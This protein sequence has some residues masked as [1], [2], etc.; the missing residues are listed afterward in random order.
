[1]PATLWRLIDSPTGAMQHL[2][3]LDAIMNTVR[4]ALEHLNEDS[5][6]PDICHLVHLLCMGD[7]ELAEACQGL[8]G[9]LKEVSMPI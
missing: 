9:V 4:M 3:N 7:D 6:N 1:M 8:E 5:T 2:Y